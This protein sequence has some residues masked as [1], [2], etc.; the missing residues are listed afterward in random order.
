MSME[1]SRMDVADRVLAVAVDQDVIGLGCTK[2]GQLA[3][4]GSTVL[5]AHPRPCLCEAHLRDIMPGRMSL[6]SITGAR[7]GVVKYA[8]QNQA[9]ILSIGCFGCS[10]LGS[11]RGEVC[12]LAGM[13]DSSDAIVM[14]AASMT[15]NYSTEILNVCLGV[16]LLAMAM[17]GTSAVPSPHSHNAGPVAPPCTSLGWGRWDNPTCPLAL[18]GIHPVR[19]PNV[20]VAATTTAIFTLSPFGGILAMAPVTH[21]SPTSLCWTSVLQ[22][23][24]VAYSDGCVRSLRL[25]LSQYCSAST[26]TVPTTFRCGLDVL[27]D[28][29][30]EMEASHHCW[31]AMP[32]QSMCEAFVPSH[33]SACVAIGLSC[34]VTIFVEG[35]TLAMV[36]FAGG[37]PCCVASS[38]AGVI[39]AVGD[40][41]LWRLQPAPTPGPHGSSTA[42]APLSLNH[43]CGK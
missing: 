4:A 13:I 7:G 29:C 39:V 38:S 17:L 31:L 22:R 30:Q 8:T 20:L 25:P 2:G 14:M 35:S 5:H 26:S 10:P 9:D 36:E 28:L 34:C 43:R 6:A 32:A 23:I 18:L 40:G 11:V 27:P 41:S 42:P 19:S 16:P 21:S 15:S 33:P 12:A 3:S 1:I 37:V 24:L